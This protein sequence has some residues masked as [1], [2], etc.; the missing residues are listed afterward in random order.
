MRKTLTFCLF[1]LF[2]QAHTD[3]CKDIK[4]FNQDQL[5]VIEYAYNYGNKYGLGYTMA[6][7][8][9]QESCAGRYRINF[10]DPS[11]GIYHAY[12]PNVIKRHYKKQDTPF[13]RNVVAEELISNRTFASKIALEELLYWRKIRKNDWKA[14][15]KSYNKGFSW[16]NNPNKDKQAEAYYQ[17]IAHKVKVLQGFFAKPRPPK[18]STPKPTPQPKPATPHKPTHKPPHKSTPNIRLLNEH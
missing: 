3:S 14:I 5:D 16:E 18:P 2:A 8:A 10:A 11:A 13:R 7:I 4:L 12:L 15:I 17:G 1:S 9:W 6:A